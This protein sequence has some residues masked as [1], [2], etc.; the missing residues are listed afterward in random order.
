MKEFIEAVGSSMV[1]TLLDGWDRSLEILLI[2]MVLDYLTG[3]V[4]AYRTKTVSS[5]VGYYG[6]VKK[7]SIFLVVIL[8]A[9]LDR[10][11]G[12]ENHMF[13]NC[14]AFSF[15]AN[16]AIS[17]L[18]NAGKM[19][20]KLP[21]FLKSALVKLKQQ[22]ENRAEGN[23]EQLTKDIRLSSDFTEDEEHGNHDPTTNA[24]G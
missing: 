10:I 6:L 11:I 7:A 1:N 22:N 23:I 3:V 16:D 5:S 20:M 8:A 15:T 2:V 12:G 4:A 13:R 9:Q 14:T 17:I 18:E 19:G 21:A 24:P